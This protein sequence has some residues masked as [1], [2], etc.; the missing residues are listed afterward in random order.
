[1]TLASSYNKIQPMQN[2]ESFQQIIEESASLMNDVYRF[3]KGE[4]VLPLQDPALEQEYVDVISSYFQFTRTALTDPDVVGL[5]KRSGIRGYSREEWDWKDRIR[6]LLLWRSGVAIVRPKSDEQSIF[7][8]PE[9]HPKLVLAFDTSI[10]APENLVNQ[11]RSEWQEKIK[12]EHALETNED[13]I[14]LSREKDSD[15]CLYRNLTAKDLLVG[16]KMP[17]FVKGLHTIFSQLKH[18]AE[19]EV[20][21]KF[22]GV[23][24]IERVQATIEAFNQANV[25]LSQALSS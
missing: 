9:T 23:E 21:T 25:I 2:P 4:N 24:N 10:Y 22:A 11:K 13:W 20:A 18:S 8:L 14:F 3:T 19:R 6:H 1:M 5:I 16:D 15:V 17:Q 12:Q 7:L